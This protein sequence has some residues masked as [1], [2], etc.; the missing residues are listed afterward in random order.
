MFYRRVNILCRIWDTE[1][2]QDTRTFNCIE[3]DQQQ[4]TNKKTNK[5]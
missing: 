4:K 1:N 5:V 3:E 2:N